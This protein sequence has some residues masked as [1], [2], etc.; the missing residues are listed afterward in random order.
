MGVR[1]V[2]NILGPLTNPASP[3]HHVIGAYSEPV[4]RLMADALAGMP[5]KR[6]FVVHGAG[7]WD[8]PTPLGEFLLLD[9]RDGTVRESRRGPA[10]YGL[11]VCSEAELM[12]GEAPYNAAALQRVLR[13]AEHGGHRDAL[14]LGAALALEVSGRAPDPLRAASQAAAAIDSGAASALLEKLSAFSA[15]AGA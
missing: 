4:A 10:D 1:T 8:E 14:V 15:G 12:G 9:V 11:P 3:G 7:G 6:A 13:G 5:L 2:F